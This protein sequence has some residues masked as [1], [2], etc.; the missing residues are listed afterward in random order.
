MRRTAKRILAVTALFLMLSAMILPVC[1]YAIED[2]GFED[3]T[4]V[5]V[6]STQNAPLIYGTSLS[7][8]R[9]VT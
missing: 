9:I 4:E 8:G 1:A 5:T 2:S 7:N 6:Q 3:G